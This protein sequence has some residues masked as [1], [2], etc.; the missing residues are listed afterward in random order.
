MSKKSVNF[1]SSWP[2]ERE[3]NKPSQPV[4]YLEHKSSLPPITS[5]LFPTTLTE[6]HHWLN[7]SSHNTVH[8][9]GTRGPKVR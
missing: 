4:I 5:L 6:I 1:Q 2:C 3:E 7:T 9:T 8:H